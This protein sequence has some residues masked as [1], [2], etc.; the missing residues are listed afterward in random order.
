MSF[1]YD[2]EKILNLFD[3]VYDVDPQV[4]IVRYSF[5]LK[6]GQ[7]FTLFLSPFDARVSATLM[8]KDR[9]SWIF[10][11]GVKNV[12]CVSQDSNT[13]KIYKGEN[14]SSLALTIVLRP[15]LSV[16]CNAE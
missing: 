8:R 16:Q 6:N 1:I 15:D 12:S 3:S 2:R 4:H 13:L 5:S 10:D 14:E 7:V 11:I 9:E